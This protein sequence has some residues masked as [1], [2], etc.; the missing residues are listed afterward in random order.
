MS[1]NGCSNIYQ[2]PTTNGSYLK[3]NASVIF[4]ETGLWT[5]FT[6]DAQYRNFADGLNSELYTKSVQNTN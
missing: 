2:L 4:C 3:K 5:K 1:L 6:L